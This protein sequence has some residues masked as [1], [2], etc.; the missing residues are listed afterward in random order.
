VNS[1]A[2]RPT[3][4]VPGRPAGHAG[5]DGRAAV[6]ASE[7][8]WLAYFDAL[9]GASRAALDIPAGTDDTPPLLFPVVTLPTLPMPTVFEDRRLET[10]R[11]LDRTAREIER[12][13]AEVAREIAGLRTRPM[14][15]AYH[16]DLGDTLDLVG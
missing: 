15:S 1:P 2:D 9:D 13:Q 6:S 8:E 11:L 12:R 3:G 5:R 16:T 10:V 7:L 14:R 4:S